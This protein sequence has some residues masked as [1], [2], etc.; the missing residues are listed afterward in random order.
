MSMNLPMNIF[1]LETRK[2]YTKLIVNT[3][4]SLILNVI[5]NKKIA[6]Y[7]MLLFHC[8]FMLFIIFRLIANIDYICTCIWVLV[9]YSNYYFNGCILSRIEQ[10]VLND[11]TWGG[12]VSI[13]MYPLHLFYQP[14]KQIMNDYIKYFWC[15][16]I[17]TAL[18]FKYILEDCIFHKL[19]GLSL[20]SILAPLLFIPSQCN[21]FDYLI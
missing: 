1:A 13:I 7:L 16:P 20:C 5:N 17:S 3:I 19:I 18:I 6:G 14:N 8:S 10:I 21:I 12:P 11:K 9:I 2:K 15:A 4:S